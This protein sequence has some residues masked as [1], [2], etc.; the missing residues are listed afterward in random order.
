VKVA[1]MIKKGEHLTKEGSDKIIKIKA[2]MT[3]KLA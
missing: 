2:G 1:E 3:V